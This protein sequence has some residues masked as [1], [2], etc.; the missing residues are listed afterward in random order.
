MSTRVKEKKLLYNS[1]RTLMNEGIPVLKFFEVSVGVLKGG[2]EERLKNFWTGKT[3]EREDWKDEVKVNE[4]SDA[5]GVPF[6]GSRHTYKCTQTPKHHGKT[7]VKV[8]N[9]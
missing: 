8:I 3:E 7:A 2:K 6:L 5:P 1:Q 4:E 9:L